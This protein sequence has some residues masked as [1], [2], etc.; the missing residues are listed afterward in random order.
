[1]L[2]LVHH[3]CQHIAW[4]SR[5]FN[6][7]G[8]E[9]R[10]SLV[11]FPGILL[12]SFQPT[13][14]ALQDMS[15]NLDLPFTEYLAQADTEQPVQDLTPPL[16][17]QRQGFSFDLSSLTNGETIRLTPQKP[18]DLATFSDLTT[19]DDA[20]QLAVIHALSN[21]LALIQGPPG[22]GKSYTGVSIIKALLQNRRAGDIGP[23]ICVCYTNHA[24]DQLLEH[25]VK[26]GI[27]QVIRIGSRSKSELLKNVNLRDLAP[28][29]EPT[30]D[31]GR[32]KY[33]LNQ[34]LTS[35]L[36][37][38]DLLL[39][40][41]TR[42]NSE[43]GVKA[44]LEGNWPMHFQQLFQNAAQGDGF[45]LVARR[46]QSAI[47]YWLNGAEPGNEKCRPIEV[48]CHLSLN[49]LSRSERRR[50]HAH[51]IQNA[52]D[53]LSEE[54]DDALGPYW[55]TRKELDT[56]F[57]EQQRRTLSEAH[58]IGVTT[59]GLARKLDVLRH[60]RSK[61]LV[62]EEAGEVLEAHTLTALLPS[63]EH[64]IFIGDHEQLRPQV[65]NYEL[66]HDNPR[67]KKIAL[68]ISLFERLVQPGL[69][70][71]RAAM[72]LSRLNVQRR[73]HT[74]IAD[75]IRRTIYPDLLD[76]ITVH[77]YP[78]VAGMKHRLFWMT[79]DHREDGADPLHAQSDSKSN[80]YE[81]S[82][83][84]A[85]A[86]HLVRQGT[87]SHGDIAVLT[88]YVRQLQKIRRSLSGTFEIIMNDRD[89]EA[90]EGINDD[91]TPTSQIA[92]KGTVGKSSLLSAL[93]VATV[94]N[95]QGEEAKVIILSFVRSNTERRCGFLKT[96][97]RINV[98]LSRARHGMYILGDAR[99]AGSVPMWAKIIK[100]L[101]ESNNIG[102]TLTLCCPRHPEVRIN[103][104]TPDDF[105]IFSP[106]DS[107]ADTHA[108]INVTARHFTL[109]LT[110][111]S[112]VSGQK[113]AVTTLAKSLAGTHATSLAR[114][115]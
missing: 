30:K 24:L 104:K 55:D 71:K 70:L 48:L 20:Q 25:L 114:P 107:N 115:E 50:L 4:I 81:A 79:H 27:K 112:D 86:S 75:L 73:M 54:L 19:L 95:F 111:S 38:M 43:E 66:C 6:K 82:M 33:L 83:V 94:D 98:S 5:R 40:K 1:M 69:E 72:P 60:L 62:C 78:E 57:K 64:A 47:D 13:L 51:W 90:L 7:D 76:H 11:E 42:V 37:E 9:V 87:Y 97:N 46:R 110:A 39:K 29:V 8:S 32:E 41:L 96:S 2:T 65:K 12:P 77:D 52:G 3:D 67:G 14:E 26:D 89:M 36:I 45:T 80:D 34:Q 22:T 88:P 102:D 16:Y 15:R 113:K 35:C 44:Y 99:T 85:L 58:V 93:R 63:I 17:A 10:I 61:V 92:T 49:A 59:S 108:P 53:Q 18:F 84:A 28:G 106:E 91:E 103:V 101:D 56:Y 23:I 105:A 100:L 21:C 109:Q 68:D 74:S 31:E